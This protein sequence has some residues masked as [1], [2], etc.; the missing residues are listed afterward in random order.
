[1]T[2]S[3]VYACTTLV[4]VALFLISTTI[5]QVRRGV[6]RPL[7]EMCKGG[8]CSLSMSLYQGK[9]LSM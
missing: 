4:I 7:T 8:L 5:R 9:E 6:P 3:V 1:M 2:R